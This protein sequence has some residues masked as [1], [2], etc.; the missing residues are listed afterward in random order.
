MRI[1]V[2]AAV[3]RLIEARSTHRPVPP[4]S[5]T[6]PGLTME[7]AY[8]IQDGLRAELLRRGDRIIGWKVGITSQAAREAMGVDQP[9]GGFLLGSG[10]YADGAR[11]PLSRFAGVAVEGRWPSA[12]EPGCLDRT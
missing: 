11:V 10:L 6:Y 1:P 4:L 12:L 7:D 8:A 9:L 3:E 5:E 2:H